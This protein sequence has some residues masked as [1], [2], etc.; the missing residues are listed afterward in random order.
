MDIA[1]LFNPDTNAAMWVDDCLDEDDETH[2][3]PAYLADPKVQEGII[4]WLGL[5]RCEEDELRLIG[6]MEGLLSW[7]SSKIDAI[8]KALSICEGMCF[9]HTPSDILVYCILIL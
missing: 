7:I 2:I 6:E 1:E 8:N 4:G 9:F 5:Q 3:P